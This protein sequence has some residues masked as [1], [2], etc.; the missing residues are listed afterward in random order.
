MTVHKIYGPPGTGKTTTLL[1]IITESG[2]PLS[3]VAFVSYTKAAV[4]EAKERVQK[5]TDCADSDMRYFATLH[6]MNFRLLGLQRDLVAHGSKLLEFNKN[7]RGQTSDE[8]FLGIEETV[9]QK[10]F[11]AMNMIRMYGGSRESVPVAFHAHAGLYL[12]FVRDYFKW[13][14]ENEYIDFAGMIEQGLREHVCP[15]VQ[16]L[17]ID[18]AQDMRKLQIEQVAEWSSKI[19]V[20]YYAGDDDQTIHEWS[21]AHSHYFLNLPSHLEETLTET[22]RLPKNVLEFSL[23]VINKNGNRKK[24]DVHTKKE[25]SVISVLPLQSIC[26]KIDFKRENVVFL[27]RNNFLIRKY[28]LPQLRDLHVPLYVPEKEYEAISFMLSGNKSNFSLM[29]IEIITHKA[30]FPASRYFKHGS[31]KKITGL[32]AFPEPIGGYASEKLYEMGM[33]KEFFTDLLNKNLSY[34]GIEKDKIHFISRMVVLYGKEYRPVRISTI[35]QFKGG[36]A[37]TVVVLPDISRK[38]HDNTYGTIQKKEEE[39]RVWYVAITRTKKNL[40]IT[41]DSFSSFRYPIDVEAKVFLG[42]YKK[43]AI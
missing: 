38:T 2:L 16:M 8:L 36:E 4:H 21:G 32:L 3:D 7:L 35:H 29:D 1:R 17:V 11:N 39:R 23:F 15:P 28:L 18:E 27:V 40:F 31:K 37:D 24:K 42:N 14:E 30:L 12:K 20:T 19:P 34:L 13:L 26:K 9:E 25:D 22:Y 6:S 43:L 10:F 41:S 5:I 33:K